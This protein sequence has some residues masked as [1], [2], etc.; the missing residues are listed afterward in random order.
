[1]DAPDARRADAALSEVTATLDLR[2]ALQ[3][4]AQSGRTLPEPRG[5]APWLQALIDALCELSS[6]DP[7][8]GL[9]NRRQFELALAQEL[10][11]VARSG[12]PSLLLT[13]DIDHFKRINDTHGH[14]AGDAVLKAVAARL[15]ECVRPMD[16]VAR[17]GGEEFAIV[18]PHCSPS[19]GPTVAE[20][21]RRRIASQR[22]ALPDGREITVTVS[23]GGAFAPPWVRSTPALWLER[24]DQQLYRAKA[25]GRN[26]ACFEP[27]TQVEVSAEERG[28]LFSAPMPLQD[29]E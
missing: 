20:R 28:L 16:T 12:D 10:G 3:L 22:I 14:A 5:A 24:A 26:R 17:V 21:I 15:L 25:E 27:V 6:R 4:V 2:A 19:F 8:T 1:M 29:S 23:L 18:L 11:R 9:A 7:L 13:L